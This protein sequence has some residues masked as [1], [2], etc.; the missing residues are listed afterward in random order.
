MENFQRKNYF[1]PENKE[2]YVEYIE[3]LFWILVKIKK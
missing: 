1:Y 3:C 2:W